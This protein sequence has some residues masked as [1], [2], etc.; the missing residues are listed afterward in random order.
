MRQMVVREDSP[1]AGHRI[2]DLFPLNQDDEVL[3]VSLSRGSQIAIPGPED[4]MRAGD[5]IR[6][7]MPVGRAGNVRKLF[8]DVEEGAESVVIAG[9]GTRRGGSASPD[10]RN[11]VAALE[12]LRGHLRS[13]GGADLRA[14]HDFLRRTV[15]YVSYNGHGGICDQERQHRAL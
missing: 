13:R 9:G 2:Q 12:A 15:P 7:V 14:G 5:R 1:A 6:V 8:G 10:Q 11:G 4:V 3:A